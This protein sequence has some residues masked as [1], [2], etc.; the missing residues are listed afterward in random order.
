MRIDPYYQ[1]FK[2]E[3]KYIKGTLS[4]YWLDKQDNQE[5]KN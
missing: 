2:L 5:E 1:M 3:S 4:W